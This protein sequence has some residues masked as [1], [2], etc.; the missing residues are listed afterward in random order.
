MM[1]KKSILL[2]FILALSFWTALAAAEDSGE[3]ETLLGEQRTL[4]ARVAELK[5]E[6]DFLLFQKVAAVCD[7]KY[8]ILNL[9][10]GTGQLKYKTR[11]LRDITFPVPVQQSGGPKQGAI[12]LTRKIDGPKRYGLIFGHDLILRGK[13][14]LT[15]LESDILPVSLGKKDLMAIFYALEPGAQAYV[16]P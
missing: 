5:Q 6:Q 3:R 4:Q 11:V 15:S 2:A 7:S 16:L 13:K 9:S 8:L 14:K 10:S 1:N 12:T